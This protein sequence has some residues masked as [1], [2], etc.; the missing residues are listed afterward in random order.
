MSENSYIII[1]RRPTLV[2]ENVTE[3]KKVRSH[4]VMFTHGN[5]FTVDMCFIVGPHSGADF[6]ECILLG[7]RHIIRGGEC[8]ESREINSKLAEKA[9]LS[10]QRHANPNVLQRSAQPYVDVYYCR[11][12]LFQSLPSMPR[13]KPISHKQRKAQLQ[14]KRAIKRGDI[15]LEAPKPSTSKSG[16]RRVGPSSRDLQPSEVRKIESSRRHQ[17]AFPKHSRE[18]LARSKLLAD[19]VVLPRPITESTLHVPHDIMDMSRD[20]ECPRRPKWRY[21]MSK[22]EVESNETRLF[23]QWREKTRTLL[24]E[25]QALPED[26]KE[27]PPLDNLRSPSYYEHNLEVWRQL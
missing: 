26:S 9:H 10:R 27:M 8:K 15:S 4:H 13:R 6:T 25:W 1:A 24:N 17:S 19:T 11:E 14:E 2:S 12:G 23:E 22:K 16:R 20:L 18:F 5:A 3:E 21:D 7:D